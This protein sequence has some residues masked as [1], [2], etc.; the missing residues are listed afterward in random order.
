MKIGVMSDS[1]GDIRTAMQACQ[2]MGSVDMILHAGDHY[3]DGLDIG[4][5]L[6]IPFKCV[7]GNCDLLMLAPS[8]QV[9]TVGGK[10]LLLIHGHQFNVKHG[11]FELVKYGRKMR[12]DVVVFGHTH[13]PMIQKYDDLLMMNPGSVAYPRIR[14]N[15]SFGML[16]I[17]QDGVSAEIIIIPQ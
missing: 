17:D 6:G 10:R 1:H 13:I 12:A 7:T 3:R 2:L 8:Q 9:V 14:N 16:T 11:I 5:R 15:R 4:K